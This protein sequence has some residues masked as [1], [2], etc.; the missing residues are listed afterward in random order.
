[1][2]RWFQ[3]FNATLH[4]VK[5]TSKLAVII[6][7]NPY[8]LTTVA[9]LANSNTVMW[10]R[11]WLILILQQCKQ[12]ALGTIITANSSNTLSVSS[13]LAVEMICTD[14]LASCGNWLKASAP[15]EDVL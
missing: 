14:R 4:D 13:V 9:V 3:Y 5:P 6:L 8:R 2:H 11:F 7:A 12:H 1:M 15:V 10:W